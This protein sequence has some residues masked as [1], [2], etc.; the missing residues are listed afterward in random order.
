KYL[1]FLSGGKANGDQPPVLSRKS[2]EEMWT[3]ILPVEERD[4]IKERIGLS[5]F[6]WTRGSKRVVGHTGSQ[7][8]F[9]SFFYIEPESGYGVIGVIN[10]APED[11]EHVERFW[12]GVR[13]RLFDSLLK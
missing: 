4:G 7:R 9:R 11:E 10:T 1:A 2:L 3:S 5:F 12:S 8:G 6:E 13:T